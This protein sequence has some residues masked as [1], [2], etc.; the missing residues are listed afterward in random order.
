MEE[1]HFVRGCALGVSTDKYNITEAQCEYFELSI[2]NMFTDFNG[3]LNKSINKLCE[4]NNGGMKWW[5]LSLTRK[6]K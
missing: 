2:M 5:K 6:E 3:D 4:K 1:N